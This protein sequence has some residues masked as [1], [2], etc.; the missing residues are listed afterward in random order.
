MRRLLEYALLAA[1]LI[2]ADRV[3]NAGELHV[4]TNAT[5]GSE[6]TISTSGSG[7][8]TFYL[9][10]PGTAVKRSIQLGSDVHL[11]AKDL[12]YS[13]SYTAV[14]GGENAAAT[15]Y[16]SPGKAADLAFLA[17]PSRVPAS[18][19]QVISGTAFVFDA[20]HNL[21]TQPTNVNFSLG[22][23]GGKA[24]ARSVKTKDGVAYVILDSERQAGPAQ[25]TSSLDDTNVR[26]VVQVVASD[27]CNLRMSAKPAK[28][29]ILVETEPIRDCAGNPV[30]DGTIVT[31]T[32]VDN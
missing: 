11:S 10:G 12:Q 25:F 19:R 8:A 13:G 23:N 22:V 7:S 6:A 17:R 29:A 24:E 9:F 27:P 18:T 14:L 20:N 3:A 16:V 15:F 1:A 4:P 26:R 5:A 32:E 2:F 30:P 21:V 28:N 31:F